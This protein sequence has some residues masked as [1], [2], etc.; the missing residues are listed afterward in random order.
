[1]KI[2]TL[3]L[4]SRSGLKLLAKTLPVSTLLLSTLAHSAVLEEVIVTAQKR[5]QNLQDVGVSVTAFSG[6]QI[7]KFGFTNSVDVIA[8]T[9]N[10]SFGTPTAEG[11]NASLTLRGVGLS[12]FNDNNEG[13]VAVYVDEVYVSA[14]SGVTFQLFDLERV[15]VLRGPQGTLYGRN[16]TG[17][18]AHFV[19]AKPGKET[20]GYIELTAAENNQF[21]VE[22]AIGGSLTDNMQA[23]LSFGHNEHDGYVENRGPGSND[24]NNT[25]NNTLRLQLAIQPSDTFNILLNAHGS[26]NDADMGAWQHESTYSPDGGI[27]SLPLPA[28]VNFWDSCPGC[29]A[30]GYVDN[31][32]DPWAG[33]YDR[34]GVL[35]IENSGG[36]ANLDWEIGDMTFT[37]ITAYENFQRFYEE[38]TDMSPFPVIHN[39]YG[40]D[41][42][43]FTQEF[44]LAGE[45][46]RLHWVTGF[47]YYDHEVDG[48]FEIDAS[49]IDFIIGNANY[50]QETE[51]W[52]LFGQAEYSLSDSWT[53]IGG[54]RYTD[55]E[56]ELDYLSL[57]L[58]G[59]LPPDQNT[60]YD[61]NETIKSDN[62]TGK[63]ELDW[64]VSDDTLLYGSI[65]LGTKSAGFNTGL[66]D[67]TG[68]F[69][70]TNAADVPYDEE[71]LTSYEIGIKSE[72]FGGTSRFNASVFYYDYTDFQAFAFVDLN[73][74]IFNTDA[75]ITGMELEF[76]T[77]PIEGLEI[78]LGAG[79]L[80]AEAKDIPLNDGSG[81]TR[82]R[83]MTL[84]PDFSLNGLIRYQFPLFA[85]SLALQTDFTYQ[86]DTYF[87]IQNHPISSQDAY[88]VWN[89]R[90][91]Y[92]GANE[93]WSLTAFVNN[94]TEEEYKA[95]SFDV[96]NL[97]GFNQVTYGRPRW[98]GVTFNYN[99]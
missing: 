30:F 9:P 52:S 31:D 67:E 8:Q 89:A 54:L 25:D 33:A 77:H 12:D 39:T 90:V 85:G 69:G 73:Q 15:E 44:R 64:H 99:W 62:V 61:Y 75:T 4:Q 32:G 86:D 34:D 84:A 2:D 46:E 3:K 96:T 56:R 91:S 76:V 5:E 74:V 70:M 63:V 95:Y 10:L 20:E 21:K 40:A 23:R 66:L 80:D 57:E 58:N 78:L 47:F 53:L 81:I 83:D 16:T 98:A 28:D 29:D 35:E 42:D 48:S 50:T 45:S 92:Y 97:F 18:L 41:A 87:D 22:G 6:E 13:P 49:G 14:L 26:K 93:N 27:T 82:D 19:S 88:D 71:E 37:S 43:Q 24:A 7:R 65:S 38:D 60:M 51:S 1:M 36:S 79:F 68:L 17:G 94:L 72:L 55:E 11:N 59:L